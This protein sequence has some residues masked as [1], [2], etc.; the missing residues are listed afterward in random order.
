MMNVLYK[1]NFALQGISFADVQVFYTFWQALVHN[2][3]IRKV[4]ILFNA[5]S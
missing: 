4:E 5:D 1:I 2:S 3:L